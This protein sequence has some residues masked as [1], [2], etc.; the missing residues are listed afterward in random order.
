MSARLI[1]IS[2]ALAGAFDDVDYVTKPLGHVY[3]PLRYARAPHE[4]YLERFGATPGRVALFV[5]M[6]PGP[7]GMAQTGV[8]FGDVVAVR[9][10]MGIEADVGQPADPVASRPIEGFALTRR[11]GSGKRLWGWAEERWGEAEDF[12]AECFVW[13]Y[14]PLLFLDTERARNRTPDKLYKKD[15]ERVFPPCDEA[16]GQ[17]IDAL[18]PAWVIGV[19]KFA[20]QRARACVADRPD[21]PGVATVLHPSPASP[22][23]NRG[24]RAQAEAQLEEQGVRFSWSA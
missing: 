20:T 15:R 11:E 3:N 18:E 1:E 9:D 2:R 7:W 5:G 14:C 19:G 17:I 23:A 21:A 8:P 22:A 24:W 10:W 12:F 4:L 6:N 16:L 13:N